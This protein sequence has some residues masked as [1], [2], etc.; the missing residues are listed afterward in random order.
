MFSQHPLE[1][2]DQGEALDA[3]LLAAVLV[4]GGEVSG[5]S[6]LGHFQPAERTFHAAAQVRKGVVVPLHAVVSLSLQ[7]KPLKI[8]TE[9]QMGSVS[10]LT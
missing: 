9:D 1:V 2:L 10:M 6:H 7:K 8:S 5:Q 4:N 3:T